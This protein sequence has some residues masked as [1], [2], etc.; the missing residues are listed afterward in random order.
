MEITRKSLLSDTVTTRDLDITPE[1]IAVWRAGALLEEA[2]PQ[3]TPYE[4]EF[5]L[6]GITPQEYH[7]ALDGD[8]G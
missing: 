1:Q 2:F 4:R 6:T 7:D 5:W 8:V 3:L